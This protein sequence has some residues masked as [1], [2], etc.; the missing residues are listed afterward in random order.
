[1]SRGRACPGHP[2]HAPGVLGEL[3]PRDKPEDN[4]CATE[5]WPGSQRDWKRAGIQSSANSAHEV[6][7]D[8]L[9]LFKGE[10][11]LVTGSASNI[12][13]A[14]TVAL[15]AEGGG[16]CAASMSMP[17]ATARCRRES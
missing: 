15:A 14:I 1:L 7:R 12:G 8:P 4:W 5:L 13:R 17:L 2:A 11:A 10:T 16:A 6:T 9:G 3:D